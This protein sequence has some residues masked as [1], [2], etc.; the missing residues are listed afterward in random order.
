[1]RYLTKKFQVHNTVR[2]RK[3]H[4]HMTSHQNQ[5]LEMINRPRGIL[6][7][8]NRTLDVIN[9]EVTIRDV[10]TALTL[11][12]TLHLTPVFKYN[13]ASTIY[14]CALAGMVCI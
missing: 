4:G 1:M 3:Q 2:L 8:I 5:T 11:T 14:I 10:L 12:L 13:T 7:V 6:E 9:R